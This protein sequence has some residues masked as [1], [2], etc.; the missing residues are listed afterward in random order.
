MRQCLAYSVQHCLSHLS[1][2][3]T[4][5]LVCTPEIETNSFVSRFM[6]LTDHMVDEDA[7]SALEPLLEST[8]ISEEEKRTLVRIWDIKEKIR[9]SV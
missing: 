5:I 1:L 4:C 9:V 7:D 8:L 2:C 3:T 6:E